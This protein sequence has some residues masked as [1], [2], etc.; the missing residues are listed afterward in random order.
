[1]S[2]GM[3]QEIM[4]ESIAI[5]NY[6]GSLVACANIGESI[7]FNGYSTG[8][9]IDRTPTIGFPNDT[10]GAYCHIKG[11]LFDAAGNPFPACRITLPTYFGS[12]PFGWEIN[13]DSSGSFDCRLPARK[14]SN[15]IYY[16]VPGMTGVF[17]SY[18]VHS[19]NTC[20][21]PDSTYLIDLYT[22]DIF[23]GNETRESPSDYNI[24]LSPNPFTNQIE[25]FFK[26]P[27]AENNEQMELRIFGPNGS[28]LASEVIQKGQKSF[29]WQAD[30]SFSSGMYLY[31]FLINGQVIKSGKFIKR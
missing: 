21:R 11:R 5:G 2:Y 3:Y 14:H 31:Q 4:E 27:S 8:L 29:R 22:T 7:S 15:R 9:C 18:T 20:F 23:N 13:I 24:T 25:F 28:H 1:M 6:P 26:I 17:V 12:M 16:W 19:F 10:S 30:Q